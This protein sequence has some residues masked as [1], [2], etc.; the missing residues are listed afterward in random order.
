MLHQGYHQPLAVLVPL[1]CHA[2]A[3]PQARRPR[4]QGGSHS[5]PPPVST[6]T[7]FNKKRGIF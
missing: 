1:G 2:P 7:V 3:A 6:G 5:P 4:E